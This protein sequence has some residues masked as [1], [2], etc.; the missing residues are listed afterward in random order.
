MSEQELAGGLFLSSTQLAE[1]L[2]VHRST[3][4]RWRA[5]G[6]LPPVG[7]IGERPVY[8]VAQADE[9]QRELMSK[10]Q[11]KLHSKSVSV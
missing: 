2:G 1:R 9:L 3:V 10:Q 11:G 7:F 4:A 5:D 6:R 8:S